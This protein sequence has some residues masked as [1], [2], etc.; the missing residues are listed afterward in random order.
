MKSMTVQD[1]LGI[2]EKSRSK[3]D[4]FEKLSTAEIKLLQ[5]VIKQCLA[6][7]ISLNAKTLKKLE[8]YKNPL[9]R[10]AKI[11]TQDV[12]KT[13]KTLKQTGRGLFSVLLPV[14]AGLIGSLVK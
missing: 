5:R 7:K 11:K 1:I 14:V 10:I 2:L 9:R 3:K 6:K 4:F 8:K 13:R 12:A